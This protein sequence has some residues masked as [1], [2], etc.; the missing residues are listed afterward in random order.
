MHGTD[1]A[2][3]THKR[4]RV[5]TRGNLPQDCAETRL[6]ANSYRGARGFRSPGRYSYGNSCVDTKPFAVRVVVRVYAGNKTARTLL[7]PRALP[8]LPFIAGPAAS[9]FPSR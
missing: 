9:R 5:V 8:I 1:V 7:S 4:T 6:R 2:I 3:A